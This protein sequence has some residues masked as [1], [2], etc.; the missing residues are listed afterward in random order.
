MSERLRPREL[1]T[2]AA[3]VRCAL[4]GASVALGGRGG[5]GEFLH[6]QRNPPKLR[7]VDVE[8]VVQSAPDPQLGTGRGTAASCDRGS[9]TAFGN[10]WS[11]VV[12]YKSG[13]RVRISVRVLT[14][15]T[16][17]GRYAGGGAATGCCI[18]LPGTR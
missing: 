14:D 2:A 7:P 15:G 17:E 8:R 16:Y 9:D 6:E 4:A 10:P 13:R 5:Q 3:V 1:T 11:C 12:S 18:D